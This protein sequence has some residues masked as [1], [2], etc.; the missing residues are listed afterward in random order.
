MKWLLAV[1][2]LGAGGEEPPTVWVFLSP[3]APDAAPLFKQLEGQRVRPVLLVER[4]FGSREPADAFLSTVQAAGDLRAFDE[5]GLR[6][7]RRWKIR[8]VPAVAVAR[9]DRVH[10]AAGTKVNVQELLRCSR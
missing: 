10:V 8:R 6:M 7:A 2:L 9:G 3:D 5:E 1:V 4:Y